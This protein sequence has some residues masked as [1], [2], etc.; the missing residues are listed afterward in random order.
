M[1]DERKQLLA[2]C[3]QY[4]DEGR[5]PDD[6]DCRKS[7]PMLRDLL[8]KLEGTTNQP[9]PESVPIVPPKGA[10]LPVVSHLFVQ[11]LLPRLN[12][13]TIRRIAKLNRFLQQQLNESFWFAHVNSLPL[14]H[15]DSVVKQIKTDQP[16]RRYAMMFSPKKLTKLYGTGI[17][18][19]V[20]IDEKGET[21]WG[22]KQLPL[23]QPVLDWQFDRGVLNFLTMENELHDHRSKITHD[24]NDVVY[25]FV[26][27]QRVDRVKQWYT[28]DYYMG[29][30][31][32]ILLFLDGTMIVDKEKV[33]LAEPIVWFKVTGD[34][35]MGM[36][37]NRGRVFLTPLTLINGRPS[38]ILPVVYHEVTDLPAPVLRIRLSSILYMIDTR[39]FTI[40]IPYEFRDNKLTMGRKLVRGGAKIVDLRVAG[41]GVL[42]LTETGEVY[43]KGYNVDRRLTL[44]AKDIKEFTK[45]KL[46]HVISLE[47]SLFTSA[48]VTAEGDAYT[49]GSSNSGQ[50]GIG[51]V[52][53]SQKKG[54]NRVQLENILAVRP[55]DGTTY[56]LGE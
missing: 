5:L 42:Q 4:R 38:L 1:A 50:L 2:R 6:F 14:R 27:R 41:S 53:S 28:S 31:I 47:V 21:T 55:I 30:L 16:W 49:A 32:R 36:V 8:A 43:V 15:H 11:L 20:D 52:A 35:M 26:D 46:E 23:D 24:P 40:E 37:T 56:F 39:G 18:R 10:P 25:T 3:K 45:I 44:P 13:V 19:N 34:S 29:G 51:K 9:K 33:Q 22:P 12:I 48:F 7:T 54:L 17:L